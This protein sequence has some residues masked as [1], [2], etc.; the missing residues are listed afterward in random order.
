MSRPLYKPDDAW[1][2]E[3]R[4]EAFR[5]RPSSGRR[6]YPR[7]PEQDPDPEPTIEELEPR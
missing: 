3:L 1:D 7:L 4:R 6:V 5:E 2:A